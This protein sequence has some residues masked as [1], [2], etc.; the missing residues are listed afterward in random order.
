VPGCFSRRLSTRRSPFRYRSP[1]RR[2]TRG[3]RRHRLPSR[4]RTRRRT[5][6][7]GRP[8]RLFPHPSFEAGPAGVA[9]PA[10]EQPFV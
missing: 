2:P 9:G 8:R 7:R 3:R 10:A 5:R 6:R 1:L 4:S